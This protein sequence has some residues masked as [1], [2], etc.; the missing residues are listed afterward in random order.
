MFSPQAKPQ[1]EKKR[2]SDSSFSVMI[3]R[4][5][6]KVRSFNI[7]SRLLF[8]ATLVFVLYL[9]FSAVAISRYFG[10][11]KYNTVQLDLLQQLQNE[12]EDTKKTLNQARQRLKFLEDYIDNSQGK[13]ENQA[14][15]PGPE[16]ISAAPTKPV[17]QE[18]T[19]E[20]SDETDT[21]ESVVDI[22]NLTTKR[23]WG[24][25]SVKFRLIKIRPDRNQI[26]GY[27]FMIATNKESDPPQLWTH[28][29]VAL[30]NGE[31]IN[32]KQ[33]Q[34]FKVRNYRIIRGRY[35]LDSKSVIPSFL[36]ILVYDESGKLIL[37]K[38]FSIEE[39]P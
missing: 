32:Y 9:I 4:G 17:I 33:G 8:W 18:Q 27:I 24:R 23:G 35:F 2:S 25:V 20:T 28:P 14:E 39:A 38:E 19:P 16:I 11:L 34:V 3:V 29:K 1:R 5:L 7:S 26:K 21:A 36:K 15:S 6:G 12:I 13:Q 22:K 37:K 10:E 30:K 31:P